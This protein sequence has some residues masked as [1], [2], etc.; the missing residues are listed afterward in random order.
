MLP[1]RRRGFPGPRRPVAAAAAILL[2]LG[3]GATCPA[4]RAQQAM[5]S[6]PVPAL[7]TRDRATVEAAYNDFYRPEG[8]VPMGFT[9]NVGL[10][11]PGTVSPGF[12]R[13][14][15]ERVNFFRALAGVAGT[16]VFDPARCAEDQAAALI[17]SANRA[18][19][20]FPPA[21][22]RGWSP[23]GAAAA[24][25]SNLEL[26][27]NGPEAV[28]LGYMAD[29]GDNNRGVAGHRRWLLYPNARVFGSGDVVAP[30]P[31][32]YLEGKAN[33]LWV[34]DDVA[35]PPGLP[36]RDGFYAWP[37][38][39]WVPANLVWPR[40]SFC[41]PAS[42]GVDLSAATVAV[43]REDGATLTVA[44]EGT[45]AGGYYVD[46][47]LVF[48]V[49]E[50]PAPYGAPAAA[51]HTYT[52]RVAGV[53]G[54]VGAFT[55]QV[56]TFT[57]AYAPPRLH[58]PLAPE[59]PVVSVAA[60]AD[61]A[62]AFVV[63][64]AGADPAA[65]LAVQYQVGGTAVGGADYRTLPGVATLPAGAEAVRV[66]VGPLPGG[67]GSGRKVKLTL[68]PAASDADGAAAAYTVGAPAKAKVKL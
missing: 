21:T 41:L 23:E 4:T 29:A 45:V 56:L 27:L 53:G 16:V 51:G 38:P 22:W 64:R 40:W 66:P 6:A 44:V 28:A 42:P 10:G 48:A 24:G 54:P 15:A 37:P 57:P 25:R 63:S 13:A 18:L 20:H 9:G 60:D 50:P 30:G 65:A 34:V 11:V 58:P 43:T 33:A 14:T 19:D 26:G 31:G 5:I 61:G 7:D 52:V 17:M 36:P 68:R 12:L 8:A 59:R 67:V 1:T 32:S 55:Y 47:A 62:S 46:P 35:P 3:G 49:V 39:G 2:V